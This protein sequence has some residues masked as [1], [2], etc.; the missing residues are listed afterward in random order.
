MK[1]KVET[2]FSDTNVKKYI[3]FNSAF[4][5]N[6]YNN[7]NIAKLEDKFNDKGWF[8]CKTDESGEYDRICFGEPVNFD[9]WLNLVKEGI[10]FFDSGMYEGNKRPYSQWRANNKF[11]DSLITETYK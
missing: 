3:P 7:D 5:L 8:T 2:L 1:E 9:D 4:L 10:V 6:D 11:W